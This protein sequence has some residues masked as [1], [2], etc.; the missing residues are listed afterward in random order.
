M[1]KKCQMNKKKYFIAEDDEQ[2]GPFSFN[3]LQEMGIS[4]TT[5]IWKEGFEDWT[6]A[7]KIEKLQSLL[8]I[9]PPKLPKSEG[10][11]KKTDKTLNVNL[12]I[13]KPKS[14]IE[15]KEKEL[16]KEKLKTST[17]NTILYYLKYTFL[18]VLFFAFSF[19]LHLNYIHN[20]C[21]KIGLES[22]EDYSVSGFGIL[23]TLIIC[24][25]I[26]FHRPMTQIYNWFKKYSEKE[27]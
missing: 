7:G 4:K 26:I 10:K 13:G 23:A 21:A 20:Y 14:N 15:L 9:T 5:L 16:A 3:E 8:K 17:A 1:Y 18:A 12:G 25:I 6:E 11:K 2:K 19:W 22:Y 27:I 24:F